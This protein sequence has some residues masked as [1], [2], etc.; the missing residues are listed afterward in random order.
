MH[1]PLRLPPARRDRQGAEGET[2]VELDGAR[3]ARC[4]NLTDWALGQYRAQYADDAI[5]KSD[6]FHYVYAVLH[7]PAYRARYAADLKR[8]LPRVP[9]APTFHDL[10]DA[11]RELAALHVGYETAP[12][13]PLAL[14]HADG[15][16]LTYRVDRM[17]LDLGAGTLR[18]NDS[19]TLA[20]IP[21]AAHRYRLGNR[22]AL[23]WLADQLR[24]KTDKRSGIVHDPN[25]A[26]AGDEIVGLVR[27]VTHVSVETVRIVEGL[28]GLGLP[29]A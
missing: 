20:G 15:T 24:V 19:L 28:P 16:P 8:T 9:F 18:L 4:D 14:E 25:A 10:A 1:P 13:H 21:E 2:E 7:H 29:A 3:Y 26:F 22:S 12:E 23:A 17:K 27:R 6:V 11:G 5:T